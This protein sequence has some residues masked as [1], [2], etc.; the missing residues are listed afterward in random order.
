MTARR[1]CPACGAV[2]VSDP[3]GAPL[4]C[5]GCDW[6]L[7]TLEEWRGLSPFEQGYACY[8]Q[9]A[10][11]TSPLAEE[12]HYAEGTPEWAEFC[13]GEECG[14]LEAQDGEE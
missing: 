4:S 5:R 3:P 9:A 12:N 11:P 7:I 10:W 14:M 2:L 6:R 13:R 1:H 8:M